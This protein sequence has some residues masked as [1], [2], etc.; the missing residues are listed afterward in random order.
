VFLA[1][2][3]NFAAVTFASKILAV[4]TASLANCAAPTE[5]FGGFTVCNSFT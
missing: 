3:P 4:V 1:S 5:A 2:V